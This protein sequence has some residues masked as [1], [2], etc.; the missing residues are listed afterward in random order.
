MKSKPEKS[1][2]DGIRIHE[3]CDAG[4]VLYHLSYQA[5]WE[6]VYPKIVKKY[7][8]FEQFELGSERFVLVALTKTCCFSMWFVCTSSS[9]RHISYPDRVYQNW[10]KLITD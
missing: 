6:P 9:R 8:I 1:G 3:I 4:A 5:I 2:L 7:H 10:I